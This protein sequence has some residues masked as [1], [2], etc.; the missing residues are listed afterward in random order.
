MKDVITRLQEH[1]GRPRALRTFLTEHEHW[2]FGPIHASTTIALEGVVRWEEWSV[3]DPSFTCWQGR[4]ICSQ[5]RLSLVSC[6]ETY[7]WECE[8]QDVYGFSASKSDLNKFTSLDQMAETSSPEMICELTERKLDANLAHREIRILHSSST[9]DCLVRFTWNKRLFLMNA[10]GSHHFAAARYIA[11][12]LPKAVPLKV[13][14][15][16]YSLQPEAVSQ[17]GA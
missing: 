7:D 3:S 2:R 6:H 5:P 8:I 9:S 13:K 10:G 14:L 4:D 16:T 15:K 11:A 12:R 17:A 1:S